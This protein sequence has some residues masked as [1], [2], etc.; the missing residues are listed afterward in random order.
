MTAPN[1][2]PR[3]LEVQPVERASTI[4]A[5]WYTDPAFHAFEE[6]SVFARTWQYVGHTSQIP[7]VGDHIT[8]LVARKP[9]LVVRAG[10]GRVHAFYNVCRHRGGPLALK[11]GLA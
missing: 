9:V 4:P 5:A 6:K 7:R 1:I 8:A 3:D 2:A 10:D 11:D